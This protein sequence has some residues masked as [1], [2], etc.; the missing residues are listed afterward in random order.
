MPED[1]IT[2]F[3]ILLKHLNTAK[4]VNQVRRIDI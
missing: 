1:R 4:A 3:S 2:S